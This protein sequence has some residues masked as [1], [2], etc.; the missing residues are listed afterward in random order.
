MTNIHSER[1]GTGVG[2]GCDVMQEPFMAIA[3]DH[4]PAMPRKE[5]NRCA[6]MFCFTW[7]GFFAAIGLVTW[8]LSAL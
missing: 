2:F 1:A 7:L 5:Q 8:V 4:H 6:V 3:H